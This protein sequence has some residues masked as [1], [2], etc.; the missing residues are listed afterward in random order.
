[1]LAFVEGHVGDAE[2]LGVMLE[3]ADVV[4]RGSSPAPHLIC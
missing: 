4:P 1:V 2:Q 3:R